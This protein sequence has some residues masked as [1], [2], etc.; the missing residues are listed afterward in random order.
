MINDI[1]SATRTPTILTVDIP[2]LAAEYPEVRSYLFCKL[3]PYVDSETL[4][5]GSEL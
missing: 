2:G 4:L 5:A 1:L 3:I